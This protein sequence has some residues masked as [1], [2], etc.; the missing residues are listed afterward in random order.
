M[1]LKQNITRTCFCTSDSKLVLVSKIRSG[2][3]LII[4]Q[5]IKIN[6]LQSALKPDVIMMMSLFLFIELFIY[7]RS[8][9]NAVKRT[10]HSTEYQ[11]KDPQL[12][13]SSL[14]PGTYTL[15]FTMRPASYSFVSKSANV[16]ENIFLISQL[17]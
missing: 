14:I 17:F 6:F 1:S 16:K 11:R 4:M 2:G 13:N 10:N 3:L 8:E 12:T 5:G 9:D 7:S 15:L